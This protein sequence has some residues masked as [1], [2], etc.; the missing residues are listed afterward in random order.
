MGI[1]FTLFCMSGVAIAVTPS[2]THSMQTMDRPRAQEYHRTLAGVEDNLRQQVLELWFPRAADKVNGGFTEGFDEQW[3]PTGSPTQRSIVYQSRLTWTAVQ[4][5]R[6]IRIKTKAYRNY[7]PFTLHGLE[8]LLNQMWDKEMGGFYWQVDAKTGKPTNGTGEKH[9]YGN[10]FGIYSSSAAY[11]VLKDKRALDLAKKA[12]S[13]LETH[14]HD[15]KNGGYYEAFNREGKPI[16]Q[17]DGNDAIGTK[18]GLKSMNSHIH[19]LEALQALYEVWPVALVRKRFEE[20]FVIVRDKVFA[21]PGYLH[22]FFK[23]DWTPVPD[24]DSFGHDIETGYLLVEAS[25]AL[26]KPTD[27]RTWNVAR[28]L[29][30]HALKYGWDTENGG[31]FDYGP[32]NG[33]ASGREK[34]W[35]T[36]AEG[37]NVLLLMHHRCGKQTT[38][39]WQAFLNQW[40]FIQKH[41]VDH[42]NGGWLS[43][44]HEDGTPFPGR[45][46]SDQWTECYHQGRALMNVSATLRK[47]AAE[48]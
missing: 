32:V 7:K 42:K 43:S 33:Q 20:V 10:A 2:L 46:K 35:W 40:D 36:E 29:V 28:K 14:V 45:V 27:K 21:E 8:C 48:K 6:R 4:A 47:L 30:D 25:E 26:A 17:K 18:Y 1:P 44:V 38:K 11:I 19:L 15:P 39:Y 23:P 12:F 31:F 41:Q 22:L 34:V 3:K 13:W 9:V 5:E 16:L 37:L 24:H